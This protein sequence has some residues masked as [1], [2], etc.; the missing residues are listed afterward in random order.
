M[1]RLRPDGFLKLCWVFPYTPPVGPGLW[2]PTPPAFAAASTPY[3]GNNRPIIAGSTYNTQ[4][5]PPIAYSEDPKSAFY[6]RVAQVYGASQSLT[7]DQ[8]AQGFILERFS[9]SYRTRALGKRITTGI[10]TT[11]FTC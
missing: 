10:E 1:N 5:G 7:P 6:Q 8:T 2:V 4:P 9:R 11:Q 3:L